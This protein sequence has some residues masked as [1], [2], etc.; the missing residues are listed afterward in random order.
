MQLDA[1]DSAVLSGERTCLAHACILKVRNGEGASTRGRVRSPEIILFES[2][3]RRMHHQNRRGKERNLF[4]F[5]APAPAAW[6]GVG[7]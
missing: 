3:S 6:Q 4:P 2:I 5:P 7:E 1:V